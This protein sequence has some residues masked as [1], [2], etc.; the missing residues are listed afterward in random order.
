MNNHDHLNTNND[1]LPVSYDSFI[2]EHPGVQELIARHEAILAQSHDR[3]NREF[4]SDIPGFL[5][6][7]VD[8][9]AYLLEPD[10]EYVVK[11]VK[12]S[13]IVPI[14]SQIDDLMKGRDVPGL[15]QLITASTENN[16]IVTRR[17]PGEL[18]STIPSLTLMRQIKPH[19]LEKLKDTLQYMTDNHLEF[20]NLYNV[21]FD[22]D[23]GFTV[24]DYKHPDVLS[25][26]DENPFVA[27]RDGDKYRALHTPEGFIDVVLK[28][29]SQEIRGLREYTGQRERRIKR[30]MGRAATRLLVKSRLS[31]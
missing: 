10:E 25:L 3:K 14:Q 2:E 17:A 20:D 16:V 1:Q 5:G 28:G 18:I 27:K 12:T 19:H 11:I 8:K 7:G 9:V 4:L 29:R 21:L 26:H 22:P 30:S 24:I 31:R 23:E 15:E 6:G 13:N